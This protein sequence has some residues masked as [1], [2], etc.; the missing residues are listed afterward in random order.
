[1]I[2]LSGRVNKFENNPFWKVSNRPSN[3]YFWI[4]Q[5]YND[6]S[7]NDDS[8]LTSILPE[9]IILNPEEARKTHNLKILGLSIAAVSVLA[10]AGIFFI[11]RGGPK[12]VAKG[13]LSL[14]DSVDRKLQKAKL[15]G[16]KGYSYYE[17]ILGKIDFITQKAEAVN[18]FTTIKDFAL[19]KLMCGKNNK[20]K[21]LEKFHRSMTRIFENFGKKTLENSYSKTFEEFENLKKINEVIFSQFENA[22][23]LTEFITI[24][25]ETKSKLDW[26]KF[27]KEKGIEIDNLLKNNFDSS[28]RQVRYDKIKEMTDELEKA[29][30]SKGILWF[31]SKEIVNSFVA[32][33]KMLNDKFSIQT[34]INDIVSKISYT[35]ADLY[36]SADDNILK[37]ASMLKSSDTKSLRI[38]NKLRSN[39]KSMSKGNY[40]EQSIMIK[41]FSDLQI[42]LLKS[43]TEIN[44]NSKAIFTS[45]NNLKTAYFSY[46]QGMLQ[47]ILDVYKVL[48]P[49]KQ[50]EKMSNTISSFIKKMNKSVKLETGDF[51][52]KSR[53]LS[54]GSAP[55]DFLAIIAGL[56]TLGYYLGKSDNNKER[57]TIA[58]KY[59]FPALTGIAVSLYGNARLFAGSKS[60]L[61]AIISSFIA[62]KVGS[63][64]NDIYE[65]HIKVRSEQYKNTQ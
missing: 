54:M 15:V 37:I 46:K 13:F 9:T 62:N 19:K 11:L 31:F 3:S 14:K 63:F 52:D 30:D 55:T 60:L 50:Y 48:L 65:N 59:G 40:I 49:D 27:T 58:L 28:A 61:F 23:N 57:N 64:A 38:L 34:T 10:A 18:N 2:N 44:P 33:S 12:S 4:N 24:N 7:K 21:F 17:F 42:S 8:I 53:D 29:F 45:F 43:I 39:F 20:F 6:L 26:L 5:K 47:D 35:H 32:K 36:K 22:D 16:A 56:G 41:D 1:M 51:I 25:G